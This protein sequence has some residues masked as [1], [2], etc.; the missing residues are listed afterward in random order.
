MDHA[1]RLQ[2]RGLHRQRG[3][4][5]RGGAG[6]LWLRAAR[7][8]PRPFRRRELPGQGRH[9]HADDRDARL[10]RAQC[11]AEDPAVSFL[12]RGRSRG[13]NGRRL[14][15]QP[16]AAGRHRR[17]PRRH[18]TRRPARA[19][20]RGG[21]DRLGRARLLRPARARCAVAARRAARPL[22]GRGHLPVARTSSAPPS[23]RS[24]CCWRC[25]PTGSLCRCRLASARWPMRC[26]FSAGRRRRGSSP[27]D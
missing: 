6:S 5:L 18:E 19:H 26:P 11:G 14:L 23:T 25:A 13:G 1:R 7:R 15:A 27:T 9:P 24:S 20:R 2:P 16:R 4:R 17:P 3:R 10:L 21:V 22:P 12:R 8:G